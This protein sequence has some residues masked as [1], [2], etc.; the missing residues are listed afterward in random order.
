MCHKYLGRCPVSEAF[1]RLTIEMARE[2]EK[3]ALRNVRQIRGARQVVLETIRKSTT[4]SV[5]AHFLILERTCRRFQIRFSR[6]YT[7]GSRSVLCCGQ[8]WKFPH[9]DSSDRRRRKRGHRLCAR[10]KRPASVGPTGCSTTGTFSSTGSSTCQTATLTSIPIKTSLDG[11]QLEFPN[12]SM[13][14]EAHG[15][16]L[17]EA[18]GRALISV[19]RARRRRLSALP[20]EIHLGGRC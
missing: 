20:V 6:G 5:F 3:V 19:R 18:A 13:G 12:R 14:R 16:Q 1:T 17:G 9:P 8:E 10:V 7:A 11:T 2:V 15:Q 4:R